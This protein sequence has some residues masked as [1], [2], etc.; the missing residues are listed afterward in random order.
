M[1]KDY[2]KNIKFSK[3]LNEYKKTYLVFAIILVSNIK[4]SY[5]NAIKINCK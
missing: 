1:M 4:V 5:I 2:Y 3:K